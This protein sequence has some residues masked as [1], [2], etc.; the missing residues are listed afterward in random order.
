VFD[1]YYRCREEISS[2]PSCPFH[3]SSYLMI[4]TSYLTTT[5]V[6]CDRLSCKDFDYHCCSVMVI[7]SQ[8]TGRCLLVLVDVVDV[9]DDDD[10]Y[11]NSYFF[12]EL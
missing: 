6:C 2:C 1:N 5:S 10:D 8:D 11:L 3:S 9:V 12:L 4:L 7:Y